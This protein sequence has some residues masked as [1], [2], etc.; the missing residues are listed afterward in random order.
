VAGDGQ[1][2]GEG[3][4]PSSLTEILTS[5]RRRSQQE[6]KHERQELRHC[7]GFGAKQ[8]SVGLGDFG[9]PLQDVVPL[10]LPQG[11]T[12]GLQ[13]SGET[14]WHQGQIKHSENKHRMQNVESPAM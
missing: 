7:N 2:G 8:L 4:A 1:A 6:E 11:G 9:V 10:L 5:T 12:A 14:A 13:A 3:L